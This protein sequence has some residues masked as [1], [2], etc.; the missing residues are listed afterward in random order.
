MATGLKGKSEIEHEDGGKRQEGGEK[1]MAMRSARIFTKLGHPGR[2]LGARR[3]V[4]NF[5]LRD[6]DS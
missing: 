3:V 5:R 2:N 1:K 6:P 4:L